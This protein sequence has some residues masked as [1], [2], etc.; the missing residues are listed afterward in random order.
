MKTPYRLRQLVM[1]VLPV[2]AVLVIGGTLPVIAGDPALV[3]GMHQLKAVTTQQE[4]ERIVADHPGM[5]L[6]DF[7]ASWCGPCR[8]L[9]PE[10]QA[11]AATYPK[12][13]TIITVDVDE[14]PE[15]AQ[16]YAVESIPHLTLL[17][18]GQPA[19]THRGFATREKIAKWAGLKL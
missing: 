19:Q 6:V 18:P 12:Q 17:R 8:L 1:N 13:I 2:I 16:R 14:A 3:A 15:L 9:A 7:H 11:L 10:L 5:V 4:I